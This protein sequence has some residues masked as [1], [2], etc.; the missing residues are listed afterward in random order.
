MCPIDAA[1]RTR[2]TVRARRMS[3]S[4]A[5]TSSALDSHTDRFVDRLA[6]RLGASGSAPGRSRFRGGGAVMSP[7]VRRD[8]SSEAI[9]HRSQSMRN[10]DERTRIL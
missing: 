8:R 9:S 5:L 7:T 4:E 6:K 1:E 2:L 10:S 3:V